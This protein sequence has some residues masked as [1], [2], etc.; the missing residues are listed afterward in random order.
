M[1]PGGD[2]ALA[3]ALAVSHPEV[4]V[5]G[6]GA[7]A[8]NDVLRFT[9]RHAGQIL[10]Y[11]GAAEVPL[12]RGSPRRDGF[13][14]RQ[15]E[16]TAFRSIAARWPEP[17]LHIG[18]DSA[19][20][21]SDVIR[22]RPG[23]LTLVALAP[24]TNVAELARRHPQDF[25]AIDH[26]VIFGGAFGASPWSRANGSELNIFMDPS[27][28]KLVFESGHQD[29]TLVSLD[30]TDAVAITENTV[31]MLDRARTPAGSLAALCY[32]AWC[33]RMGGTQFPLWDP[34]A[35]AIAI[36][37]SIARTETRS[38]RVQTAG[39]SFGVTTASPRGSIRL[40][41]SVDHT[42]FFTTFLNALGVGSDS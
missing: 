33:A 5:L 19:G 13:I 6:V 27:A 28:A 34:V 15:H 40:V 37:P 16:Q 35:T 17:T 22:S 1:D 2:D 23:D 30:S 24:L 14:R 31:A 10:E 8:G 41:T 4:H 36:D 42:K 26:L 21:Y 38:V 32:H 3:I 9:A 20:F 18:S 12:F 11:L 39:A 25:M 7:S 29:I